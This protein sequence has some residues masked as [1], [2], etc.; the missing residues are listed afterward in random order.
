MCL[1]PTLSLHVSVINQ[2]HRYFTNLLNNHYHRL[3]KCYLNKCTAYELN[4]IFQI[5]LLFKRE[6]VDDITPLSQS[7]ALYY[8]FSPLT[9]SKDVHIDVQIKYEHRSLIPM[10]STH[11]QRGE[12][13]LVPLPGV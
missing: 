13:S 6:H 1:L 3:L 11:S 8:S 5:F 9:K 4:N 12:M 7:T 10:V 2:V